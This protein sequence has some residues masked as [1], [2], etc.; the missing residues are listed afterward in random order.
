MNGLRHS[1]THH[2]LSDPRQKEVQSY[3]QPLDGDY[4][5]LDVDVGGPV[6]I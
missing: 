6:N 5:T 3:N 1:K 4:F 2:R